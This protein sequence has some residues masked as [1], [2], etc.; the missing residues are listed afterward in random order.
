MHTYGR[1][2][3]APVRILV[4][5][6]DADIRQI[7]CVY[8]KYS[9]FEVF[10]ASDGSEAIMLIEQSAPHLLVLDLMMRPVDG[11]EVLHWLRAQR[12]SP[13]LPVLVLTALYRLDEQVHGFEEGAIDYITKPTQPGKI[14]ERIRAILGLNNEQRTMLQR[15]RI[16]EQKTMLERVQSQPDEFA[17]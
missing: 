8:L 9:G 15:K 1:E 11:W 10:S 16:D 12:L 6:D 2:K 7:L 14:V 5:E 13:P 17:L 3:T 4:V